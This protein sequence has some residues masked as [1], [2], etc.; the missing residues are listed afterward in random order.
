[1]TKRDV[2]KPSLTLVLLE[3]GMNSWSGTEFYSKLKTA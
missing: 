1:M 3:R 2:S